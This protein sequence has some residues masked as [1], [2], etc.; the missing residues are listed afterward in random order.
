MLCPLLFI[1]KDAYC[2]L[3]KKSYDHA[4]TYIGSG[5]DG[6]IYINHFFG[7]FGNRAIDAYY[8]IS[9]NI[10]T[11]VNPSGRNYDGNRGYFNSARSYFMRECVAIDAFLWTIGRDKYSSER[12]YDGGTSV[13]NPSPAY[14]IYKIWA[15]TDASYFITSYRKGTWQSVSY[16]AHG[17]IGSSSFV[18]AHYC[19]AIYAYRW[20]SSVLN[21]EHSRNYHNLNGTMDGSKLY[22]SDI[23]GAM[24]RIG[25]L[26]SLVSTTHV[27]TAEATV[28][29][30]PTAST[31]A[32]I[33]GL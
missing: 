33:V 23:K 22:H 31:L 24:H 14:Y 2:W 21:K 32:L 17:D 16:I 5:L 10:S 13:N 6:T 1:Y 30:T 18:W 11:Y 19:E 4:R 3:S 12:F 8:W 28:L 15:I 26:S 7:I 20:V 25:L 29:A 27:F 9:S